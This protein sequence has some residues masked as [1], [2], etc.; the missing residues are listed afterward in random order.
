VAR[1]TGFVILLIVQFLLGSIVAPL[2]PMTSPTGPQLRILLSTAFI[3]IDIPIYHPRY[4]P[5][6]HINQYYWLG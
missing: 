6:G 3:S 2:Q 5:S 4:Y 1:S